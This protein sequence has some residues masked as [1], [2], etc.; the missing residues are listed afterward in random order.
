[1]LHRI[2]I[3][4]TATGESWDFHTDADNVDEAMLAVTESSEGEVTVTHEADPAFT[5]AMAAAF[6]ASGA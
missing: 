4:D 6:E 1:M 3:T 5:A 2:I